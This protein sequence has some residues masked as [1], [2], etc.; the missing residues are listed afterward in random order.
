MK[1]GYVS[2][3]LNSAIEADLIS[4][5][6]NNGLVPISKYPYHCTIMYDERDCDTPRCDFDPEKV[7]KATIQ[8]IECLGDAIAFTMTS[9]DILDEFFRLKDAGYQHSFPDL[10]IHMSILY[11]FTSLDLELCKMVLGEWMGRQITFSGITLEDI[12]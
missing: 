12:E 6:I 11:D 10:K 2:A 8:S 5:L 1:L 4:H 7:F 3:R 9:K